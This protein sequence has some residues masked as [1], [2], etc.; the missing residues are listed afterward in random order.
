[1]LNYSAEVLM[2]HTLIN[3][4]D[5]RYIQHCIS[6][7]SLDTLKRLLSYIEITENNKHN[8]INTFME[9]AIKKSIHQHKK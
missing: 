1:M 4:K 9:E 6:N 7:L 8:L 3:L 5:I 2:Y